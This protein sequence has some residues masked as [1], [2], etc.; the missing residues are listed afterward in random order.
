M[1]IIV[2]IMMKIYNIA[3]ISPSYN[4]D[5]IKAA[6]LTPFS[7]YSGVG[8]ATYNIIIIIMMKIYNIA[9]IY[10][11]ATAGE[12]GG[13]PHPVLHVLQV[14]LATIINIIII[15]IMMMKIYNNIAHHHSPSYS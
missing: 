14:G 7:M 3:C 8:L 5:T 6:V 12:Q 2:I 11:K 13:C 10:P 4:W 9:C 15:I 1:I